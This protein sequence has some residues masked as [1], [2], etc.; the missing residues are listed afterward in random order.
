M[1]ELT[2]VE[3]KVKF[4]AL[5]DDVERGEEVVITRNGRLV[6]RIC[7]IAAPKMTREE[8]ARRLA[9]FGKGHSLGGMS[10]L[11]MRDTGRK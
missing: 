3:A 1:K 10:I 7:P 6:A 8:A 4:G 5:L 11:D 9:E 2:A